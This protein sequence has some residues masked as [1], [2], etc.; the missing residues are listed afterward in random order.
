[1]RP[2]DAYAANISIWSMK[3]RRLIIGSSNKPPDDK[4]SSLREKNEH[5]ASRDAD[6]LARVSRFNRASNKN[7]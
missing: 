7:E 3:L 1:M 2:L 4:V 5:V 6:S